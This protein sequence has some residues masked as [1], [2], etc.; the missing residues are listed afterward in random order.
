MNKKKISQ[1][2]ILGSAQLGSRYGIRKKFKSREISNQIINRAKKK[3]INTLDLAD[4]Y[5]N[6]NNILKKKLKNWKICYKISQKTLLKYSKGNDFIKFFFKTL[7]SYNIESCEYFLFHNAYSLNTDPGKK[8]FEILNILK[9]S[10]FVK[11]IGVSFYSPKEI[12]NITKKFQIDVVQ[13]PVNVF[14]QR[15]LEQG[16]LKRIKR[17]KI[18]IHARSIFLQGLLTYNYKNLPN[19]FKRFKKTFRKWDNFIEEN[20][21]S[22]INESLQFILNLNE[23]DK[24]VVGFDNP[25]QLSELIN[26]S[27]RK[28]STNYL[29]LKSKDLSLIDPRKW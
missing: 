16:L 27:N 5:S 7:K 9:K 25:K 19:K 29:K 28:K 22:A 13:I 15:F 10:G 23:V 6:S 11:K 3:G 2:F 20:K 8:V 14:D 21:S 4:S 18:E 26:C 17:K 12:I 24:I 1:K